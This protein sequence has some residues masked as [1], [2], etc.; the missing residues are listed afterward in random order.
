MALRILLGGRLTITESKYQKAN[1]HAVY[2]HINQ[3]YYYA[4]PYVYS[5][6]NGIIKLSQATLTFYPAC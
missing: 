3:V 2:K 6:M 5:I 4:I 1:T